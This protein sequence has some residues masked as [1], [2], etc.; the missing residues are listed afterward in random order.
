MSLV[1]AVDHTRVILK[2]VDES[3]PGSNYINANYIQ[4]RNSSSR[5][6]VV[7]ITPPPPHTHT[8]FYPFF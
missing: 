4:V 7:E 3:V 6:L 8:Q 1:F 2:D 5:I